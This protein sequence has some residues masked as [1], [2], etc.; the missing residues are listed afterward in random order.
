[1]PGRYVMAMRSRYYKQGSPFELS[2]EDKSKLGLEPISRWVP[3]YLLQIQGRVLEPLILY[4][5]VC[6]SVYIDVFPVCLYI[7]GQITLKIPCLVSVG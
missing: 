4:W 3:E 2:S 6:V 1:M 5:W 7:G